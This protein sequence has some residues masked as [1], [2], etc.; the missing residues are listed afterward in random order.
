MNPWFPEFW[1]RGFRIV[2]CGRGGSSWKG[3]LDCS[4]TIFSSPW[5]RMGFKPPT[6]HFITESRKRIFTPFFH[7]LPIQTSSMTRTEPGWVGS[8]H[9]PLNQR[10]SLTQPGYNSWYSSVFQTHPSFSSVVGPHFWSHVCTELSMAGIL[11]EVDLRP[12]SRKKLVWICL[13][14]ILIIP[15]PSTSPSEQHSSL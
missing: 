4:T 14:T 5:C 9:K 15:V 2:F 10:E 11:S 1:H 12:S 6:S 7:S 8:V 3:G 13:F